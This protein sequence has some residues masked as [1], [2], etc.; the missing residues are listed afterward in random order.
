MEDWTPVVGALGFTAL[1][2]TP[3][4][5]NKIIK[6]KLEIA[7]INAETTLKAE[8]I[9]AKNQLEIEMLIKRENH[10]QVTKTNYYDES[11]YDESSEIA[12]RRV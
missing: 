12:K 7:R 11:E 3:F 10:S 5:V 1:L 6:F 8:E 9:R 4:I 2:V